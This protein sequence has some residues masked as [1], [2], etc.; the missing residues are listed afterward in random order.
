MMNFWSLDSV[1]VA[2]RKPE[3]VYH[4]Q[5]LSEYSQSNQEVAV[6]FETLFEIL[7][8]LNYSLFEMNV[9]HNLMV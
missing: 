5:P 6:E 8:V 4:G 2:W 1:A 9:M 7:Q 3:G